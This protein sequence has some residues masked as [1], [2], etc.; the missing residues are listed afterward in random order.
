VP[1]SLSDL[2]NNSCFPAFM[3]LVFATHNQHKVSEI[4]PVLPP[5]INFVSLRDLGFTEEIPETGDTLA[6]NALQKADFIYK[7]L[8]CA[9]FADDTGLEV[10]ALGGRPGVYSARYAGE[11]KSAEDNIEK[12]FAELRGENDRSAF[13]KTVIAVIINGK[14]ALF[15]GIVRG[16]ISKEK[17]GDKGFGYDPVF[18][19]DGHSRSFAQMS[20]EEK[21]KISHRGLAVKKF[22]AWLEEVI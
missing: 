16:V 3:R 9:C 10:N 12:L 22:I 18:I 19:P 5:S 15:E 13:F 8:N 7:K 20:R 21:N 1:L 17:M 11:N 2:S 4:Q 14:P 6:A